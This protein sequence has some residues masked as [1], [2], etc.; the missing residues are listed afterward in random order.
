MAN[1]KDFTR[2]YWMQYCT[3]QGASKEAAKQIIEACEKNGSYAGIDARLKA[4]RQVSSAPS[5]KAFAVKIV[6]TARSISF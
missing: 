4:N 3:T 1:G 2:R 6:A 5:K